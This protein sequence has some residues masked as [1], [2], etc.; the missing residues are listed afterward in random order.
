MHKRWIAAALLLLP[1]ALRPGAPGASAAEGWLGAENFGGTLAV[2][3]DYVWRGVSQTDRTP[4]VQGS[5]GYASPVGLYAGVWASNVEFGGGIEMDWYGG[6]ARELELGL[7]YDLGVNY[8]TYPKSHD[9]TELDFVEVYLSL[10]YT[11]PLPF[12]PSLGLG[13]N[14]SPDFF[15][16]DGDAH[17]VRG[18]AALALPYGL[19]LNGEVGYL[20]VQGDQTT[21]SGAGLDGKD[22][23]DYVH[24]RVGLAYD[25]LGFTL[26]L[27]W[28]DTTEAAFLE[29][30]SGYK[31]AA[32]GKLVLT[33]SRSF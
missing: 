20:D 2:T 16:E 29:S 19:G 1:L 15:G 25:L 22:G 3:T 23:F 18:T 26:D 7:S 6:F 9:P 27:S 8:Y 10:G 31:E 33:V 28:H 32:D 24:Y 17:Y 14:Y 5:F 30:Y 4:A 12:G 13:Y 11:L 21:G